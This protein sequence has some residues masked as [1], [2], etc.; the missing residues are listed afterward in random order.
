MASW[1]A[2][3]SNWRARCSARSLRERGRSLSTAALSSS[4][5]RRG[6]AQRASPCAGKSP[7]DAVCGRAGL[8][9]H[10][11]QPSWSFCR[12]GSSSRSGSVRSRKV[13]IKSLDIRPPRCGMA[14]WRPFRRKPAEGR[15]GALARRIRRACCCLAEPTRGMDVGAKE[16]VV[17]IVRRCATRA[18][19][20]SSSRPSRRPCF[21]SPTGCWSCERAKSRMNSQARRSART[22]FSPPPDW[23]SSGHECAECRCRRPRISPR[24]LSARSIAQYR[25]LPHADCSSS[26]S[27]ASRVRP[28]RR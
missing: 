9:K 16:D 20:S 22:A 5:A 1:D 17:R 6:E 11:H 21:R 28:S 23:V 13:Q 3:S 27:S 26:P 8:Q 18:S 10:L 12:A 15:A 25:A 19:R 7:R 14:P 24:R 4:P 2:A